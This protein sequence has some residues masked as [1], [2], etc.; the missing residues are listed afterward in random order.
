MTCKYSRPA[1]KGR[2]I[3]CSEGVILNKFYCIEKYGKHVVSVVDEAG[4]SA[5][6][7]VQVFTPGK[8]KQDDLLF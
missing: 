8:K 6:V 5:K 1:K 4:R 2:V 7:D 3:C